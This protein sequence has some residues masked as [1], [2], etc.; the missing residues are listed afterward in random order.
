MSKTIFQKIWDSHIVEHGENGGD[1]LLYVDLH[2]CHEVTTPQAFEGLRSAG[3]TVRR[4]N[5]TLAI[6]DHCIPTMDRDKPIADP[7]AKQQIETLE[8]NCRDFG[9]Q[10]YGIDDPKQG[11]IHVVFPEQGYVHPGMIV[12]CGDSHTATHGAFGTIAFGIGTSEVEH[13]LATQT[14]RQKMPKLFRIHGENLLPKGCTAKDLIL[15]IIGQLS[16]SGGAGFAV[17]FTGEA[18]TALTMEGR[19]TVCNMAIEFGARS[20]I[21]APDQTTFDYLLGKNFAPDRNFWDTAVKHWTTLPSS[22][23]AVY[24]KTWT[25]DASKI[26]PMITWGTNPG[27]VAP[28]SGKIPELDSFTDAALR[29]AAES[30]LKYMDLHPGT[31]IADIPVQRVF[32]GSCTNGRIEDLRS[33]AAVLDGKHLAKGVG[34]L[35]VPGSGLVKRQAEL[36]G[37]DKI[38]K[39][40]GLEWRDAGCSMCLGMNS[41]LLNAGERCASTSNRNFEGRQGRGSRTHLVSPAEAAAAGVAGHF[42]SID[43]G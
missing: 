42:V 7:V 22:T 5:K 32:I 3:R 1:D 37:L 25:F 34:G 39:S 41:D 38:F 28:I 13:V 11:V 14:I 29:Q 35:V 21:I 16:V 19:M 10:L 43:N 33:A 26:E 27:Q 2:L 40:A 17:E 31:A 8:K 4:P 20:G 30:A 12:V 18:F 6:Q 9:I 23:D 24:D 15:Y 36:E